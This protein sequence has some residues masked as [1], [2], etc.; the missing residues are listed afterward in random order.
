MAE[1]RRRMHAAALASPQVVRNGGVASQGRLACR[2]IIHDNIVACGAM[3]RDLKD[4]AKQPSR[5]W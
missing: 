1:L 2:P 5:V 3:V 4:A